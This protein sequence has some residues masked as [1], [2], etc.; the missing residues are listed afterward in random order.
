MR[1]RYAK[2]RI[3]GGTLGWSSLNMY[4]CLLQGMSLL[5]EAE[6]NGGYVL[7][8]GACLDNRVWGAYKRHF[9]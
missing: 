4:C 5:S 1:C 3:D 7:L 2:T 9:K 8:I 6:T